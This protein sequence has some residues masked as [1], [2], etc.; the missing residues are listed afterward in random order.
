MI[1]LK[2]NA[3]SR[4]IL[5]SFYS[6]LKIVCLHRPKIVV[7]GR[8]HLTVAATV[9]SPELLMIKKE[10]VTGGYIW[11]IPVLLNNV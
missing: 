2:F 7:H 9:M 4:T 11:T 8:V 10:K 1:S 5:K 3:P 6:F